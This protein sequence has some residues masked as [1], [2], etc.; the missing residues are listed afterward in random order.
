MNRKCLIVVTS[1]DTYIVEKIRPATSAN[2]EGVFIKVCQ[3]IFDMSIYNTEEI[4][5]FCIECEFENM[6]RIV[7]VL[8]LSEDGSFG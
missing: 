8:W 3:S 5:D 6:H 2:W 4:N 1:K 7:Q